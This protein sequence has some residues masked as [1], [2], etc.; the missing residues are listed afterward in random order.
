MD[1]TGNG[2]AVEKFLGPQVLI[3]AAWRCPAVTPTFATAARAH[4]SEKRQK[5]L[6]D[7]RR[8]S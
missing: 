4:I 6:V 5:C 2:L 8:T 3:T 7:V 1:R